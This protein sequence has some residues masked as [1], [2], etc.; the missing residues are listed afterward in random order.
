MD[1]RVQMI[2]AIFIV[3]IAA[4]ACEWKGLLHI[5]VQE[6]G[7]ET[8]IAP[9]ILET[10]ESIGITGRMLPPFTKQF[11]SFPLEELYHG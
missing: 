1:V 3:P 6:A 11:D 2:H 5:R 7:C 10:A 8:S 9:A 4:G